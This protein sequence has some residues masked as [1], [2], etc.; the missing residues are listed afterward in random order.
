MLSGSMR[1][2]DSPAPRSGEAPTHA[3]TLTGIASITAYEAIPRQNR[4]AASILR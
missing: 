1:S 3:T 2:N 4:H